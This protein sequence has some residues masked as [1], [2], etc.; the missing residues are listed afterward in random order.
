MPNNTERHVNPEIDKLDHAICEF[1]EKHPITPK[2]LET[3]WR[4]FMKDK[5]EAVFKHEIP[6]EMLIGYFNIYWGSSFERAM[7][8][9]LCEDDAY[10]PYMT[11]K[12]LCDFL[13]SKGVLELFNEDDFVELEIIRRHKETDHD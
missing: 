10:K 1:F 13:E 11:R 4:C 5:I 12:T 3:A 9:H 8:K 2:L 7:F 6:W